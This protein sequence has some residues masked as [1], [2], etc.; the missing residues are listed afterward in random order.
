LRHDPDA[1]FTLRGEAGYKVHRMVDH[2]YGIILSDLATPGNVADPFVVPDILR[3]VKQRLKIYPALLK[4]G[5][6][7][8][9]QVIGYNVHV[10]LLRLHT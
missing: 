6:V 1:R 2:K 3:A 8:V 7:D 9:G 5:C 10:K 4:P